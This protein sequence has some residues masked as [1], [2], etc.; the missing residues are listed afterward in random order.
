MIFCIVGYMCMYMY[1][2]CVGIDMY[3]Y[4]IYACMHILLRVPITKYEMTS[5]YTG[6]NKLHLDTY[7]PFDDC[8]SFIAWYLLYMHLPVYRI[9]MRLN[10]AVEIKQIWW[11]RSNALLLTH[12]DEKR[13]QGRQDTIELSTGGT[14]LTH[15][16][17]MWCRIFTSTLVQAMVFAC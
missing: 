14:R 11:V 3:T 8:M 4:A 10:K 15:N 16:D 5:H 13:L 2:L 1:T 12:H 6:F 9:Q 17:A 7:F